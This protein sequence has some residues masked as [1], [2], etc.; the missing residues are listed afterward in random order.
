[1]VD[2]Y[3]RMDNNVTP[4]TTTLICDILYCQLNLLL[5]FALLH[6]ED[7]SNWFKNFVKQLIKFLIC[8]RIIIVSS[9]IWRKSLNNK[10]SFKA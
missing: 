9:E 8:L 2:V 3:Y 10:F 7:K 6:P 1:M 4:L 5:L